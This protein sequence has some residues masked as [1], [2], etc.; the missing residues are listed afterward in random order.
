[1]KRNLLITLGMI[2]SSVMF[3]Q[4]SNAVFFNQDNEGFKA[5]LNGILLNQDYATNVKATD[6]TG[7]AY[8][9]TIDFEKGALGSI[10]KNIYFPEKGMEYSF[11]I[12]RNKK[13]V[14]VLRAM[15]AAPK[16]DTPKEV[17]PKQ[18][19]TKATTQPTISKPATTTE[20]K[21]VE[22]TTTTTANPV[23]TSEN[24]SVGMNMGGV[25]M[26]VNMNVN[27]NGSAM[28]TNMNTSVSQTTTTTT[29]TTTSTTTDNG[30]SAPAT[31]QPVKTEPDHYVMPGYNGKIGCAW[32]AS[33][34]D[35][36]SAKKSI[37]SK[38]FE[39]SKLTIAKQVTKAKCLFAKQVK[40]VMELF[41]YEESRL[42]FAK[43]AYDYT[44]DIDNYYLVN[45]AFQFELT[46]DDLNEYIESK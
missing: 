26:G 45:D 11:A 38:A 8:K 46:I 32:P 36:A 34:A 42:E 41:D 17:A 2:I 7:D 20:V 40:E 5:T 10:T 33:D 21:V 19:Q 1:M 31:T 23:G 4:T 39:D 16:K 15:G 13:G 29:T 24:V 44:Y 37:A 35:F 43:F 18:V 12:K 28:G 9:V 22:T 27:M 14:Y 30:V 3:A 25:D 6:L